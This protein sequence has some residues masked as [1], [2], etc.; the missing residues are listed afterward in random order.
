MQKGKTYNVEELRKA[1][2]INVKSRHI[3]PLIF[4]KNEAVYIFEFQSEFNKLK[5]I[6]Y[7]AL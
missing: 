5:L 3:K 1:G 7:S 2:F 6:A 4:I